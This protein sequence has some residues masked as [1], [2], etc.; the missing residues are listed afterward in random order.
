MR[1]LLI[2]PVRRL[3]SLSV[4]E[5]RKVRL[6]TGYPGMGLFVVAALTPPDVDVRVIDESVDDIPDDFVPDLVG[7]SLLTHS[8]NYAYEMSARYRAQG[9]RVVL[10]GIHATLNP[11]EAAAHADAVVIGEAEPVWPEL[12]DDFRSN[13]L[14]GFYGTRALTPLGQ[15]VLPR[16]DLLNRAYYQVP[17][18]V[19]ASKGCPF[20]CEF[21][22][23]V[24]AVN[25]K[26]RF[27]KAEDVAEEIRTLPPGPIMFVDDNL[28]ANREYSRALFRALR[29][30]KR[31]WV[32][33]ST[34][35][36][37]FDN[38]TATLAKEAGCLGLFIGFDSITRQ[39]AV[40]KV[41]EAREAEE[42]Y[43]EATRSMQLHGMAVVAAFVFGFDND[44]PSIFERT[45]AVIRR[46]SADL[47]NFSVL[48]PYPGTPA[49]QRLDAEG[50][51]ANR[52]WSKYVTPNVVFRPKAM[53]P[54]ELAHGTQWI[55]DQFFSLRHIGRT[56]IHT[57]LNVGWG[58][59]LLALKLNLAR[60]KNIAILETADSVACQ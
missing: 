23:L 27:R 41:P 16:R 50:R 37:A 40:R 28:Y 39:T 18:V 26:M 44:D 11:M 7:I 45:F 57:G 53:T 8:A 58:M 30:L 51:I 33:E 48:I 13:R 36:I 19:Q 9:I 22:S 14:Q 42:I 60:R 29:P 1:L 15:S 6:S 10:G 3:K 2:H 17:N 5:R 49:F 25:Y 59:S 12:I 34:W 21:C 46:S 43:V 24:P 38:E 4:R 32:G 54:R 52:D 56:A 20:D 31:K 55:H 35:H 47:V